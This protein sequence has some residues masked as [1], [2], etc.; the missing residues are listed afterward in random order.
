[1]VLEKGASMQNE[2]SMG[3][4]KGK[5]RKGISMIFIIVWRKDE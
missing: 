2:D 4:L 5:K 3:K 1:M